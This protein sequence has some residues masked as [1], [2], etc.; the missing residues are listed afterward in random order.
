MP[1]S[2]CFGC[3]KVKRPAGLFSDAAVSGTHTLRSHDGSTALAQL[4]TSNTSPL[5]DVHLSHTELENLDRR[6]RALRQ[7]IVQRR[8]EYRRR[9]YALES[10]KNISLMSVFCSCWRLGPRFSWLVQDIIEGLDTAGETER[11]QLYEYYVKMTE[12]YEVKARRAGWWLYHL[13]S[14]RT[15]FNI[16]LPAVLALQNLK[17]VSNLIMWLTWGLSLAV[18]LATGYIDL[19]RLRDIYEMYTR[20]CEHLKL[21]GWQFFALTGRYKAFTN[22]QDA[23]Q[24][25]LMRVAKIR[26]RT[27][28]REFPPQNGSG[29]GGGA[30]GGGGGGGGGV[31]GGGGGVGGPGSE[32]P[33]VR[34]GMAVNSA[35][36]MSDT[37][38]GNVQSFYATT[39][40]SPAMQPPSTSS[41]EKPVPP[42]SRVGYNYNRYGDGGVGVGSETGA[43]TA[44]IL[45]PYTRS[46]LSAFANPNPISTRKSAKTSGLRQAVAPVSRETGGEE[47]DGTFANFAPR[48]ERIHILTSDRVIL[49]EERKGTPGISALPSGRRTIG[50]PD[51]P[52][53]HP[54]PSSSTRRTPHTSLPATATPLSGQIARR[55]SARLAHLAGIRAA[56]AINN[57]H[58]TTT[59]TTTT[60]TAA[61][62]TTITPTD[63]P[64]HDEPSRPP[65]PPGFVVGTLDHHDE[66]VRVTAQ[67]TRQASLLDD[68]DDDSGTDRDINM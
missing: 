1:R 10:S 44:A 17:E 8:I 42:K 67:L 6:R 33:G 41:S 32:G 45:R 23:L 26:K 5:D 43:G 7:Q 16:I 65:P 28:D 66:E 21:E 22:H 4:A 20:A 58:H 52:M 53:D 12:D 37:R 29:N 31:G 60:T 61:A 15:T 35:G 14:L 57:G 38:S 24:I 62:A 50:H 63:H 55:P 68:S 18:S 11:L 3:R 49:D 19:F 2:M 51:H 27:I 40:R 47:E 25:F 39:H 54:N 56:A 46:K 48:R 13:Q 36:R 34:N 9:T 59:T 30:T 64:P